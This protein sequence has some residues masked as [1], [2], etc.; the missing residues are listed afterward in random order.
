[1]LS[2]SSAE[3]NWRTKSGFSPPELNFTLKFINRLTL[4]CKKHNVSIKDISSKT[5]IKVETIHEYFHGDK[6]PT[7]DQLVQLSIAVGRCV[8]SHGETD[9]TDVTPI[10]IAS[11]IGEQ[12]W[13][14]LVA[15]HSIKEAAVR[16]ELKEYVIR[17]HLKIEKHKRGCLSP[18]A[19]ELAK[20]N[21]TRDEH[22]KPDVKAGMCAADLAIK[23]NLAISVAYA[24]IRKYK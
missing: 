22:V 9:H 24:M 12:I 8:S 14:Y 6:I 19:A 17:N 3:R 15:G 21:K 23:H 1:M 7:A 11:P 20:L 10:D 13:M 5:R 18:K 16:F 4:A 2:A